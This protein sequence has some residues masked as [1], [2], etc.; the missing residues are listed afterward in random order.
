MKRNTL[1]L[2]VGMVIIASMVLA[3]CQPAPAPVVEEPAAE[4][5]VVEEPVDE[6]EPVEPVEEPVEEPEPTEEVFAPELREVQRVEGK[7]APL[8][9]VVISVVDNA[10]A[11]TQI[12][13]DAI[14]IYASGMS[15]DS[16]PEIEAAGLGY[17]QSNGLYY[18]LTFNTYGPIFEESTG[19]VN[20]FSEAK[21][22]EALNWL[23]DRD[24]INREVYNG[25]ALPKFWSIITNI[26]THPDWGGF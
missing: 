18:E 14:D 3:A 10:S 17:A 2:L 26:T 25:G 22:R 24:Y 12:Q 13:A 23:I 15:S 5:P 21:A 4:E 16:L 8:D 7:G 1:M 6:P 11:I 9:H 19:K 20:P